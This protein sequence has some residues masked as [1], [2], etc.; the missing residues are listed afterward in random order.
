MFARK[1]S[2]PLLQAQA[3]LT[4][5]NALAVRH[6]VRQFM[7]TTLEWNPAAAQKWLQVGER[8]ISLSTASQQNPQDDALEGY[9]GR[10][11]GSPPWHRALTRIADGAVS[12]LEGAHM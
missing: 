4:E 10:G 8:A 5:W 2:I 9:F 3:P 6:G 12:L 7:A 1:R 11:A